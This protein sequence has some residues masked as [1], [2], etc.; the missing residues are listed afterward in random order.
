MLGA[1]V[2]IPPYV[3]HRANCCLSHNCSR[4]QVET[5]VLITTRYEEKV[6]KKIAPEGLFSLSAANDK[7]FNLAN[8]GGLY[9]AT[10]MLGS[11][12]LEMRLDMCYWFVRASS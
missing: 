3:F 10:S 4:G 9:Y 7:E 12:L 1:P 5:E 8:Y 2:T 11:C 6:Y